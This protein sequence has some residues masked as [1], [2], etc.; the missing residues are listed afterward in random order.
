MA[1][2]LRP[3][4]RK[5]WN[6]I[7]KLR[8]RNFDAEIIDVKIHE[9]KYIPNFKRKFP[10][11]VFFKEEEIVSTTILTIDGFTWRDKRKN[12]KDILVE[13]EEEETSEYIVRE[14]AEKKA[15]ISDWG[16]KV[17]FSIILHSYDKENFYI[18]VFC[19]CNTNK[20]WYYS[21]K[22]YKF[23]RIK[24]YYITF[25][26]KKFYTFDEYLKLRAKEQSNDTK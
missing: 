19:M 16:H 11:T 1:K 20:N 17:L 2:K 12:D 21:E 24:D 26:A 8:F 6:D 23:E 10:V 13:E 4:T 7:S 25:N 18:N 22:A 5:D 9:N 15:Y 3:P 14:L